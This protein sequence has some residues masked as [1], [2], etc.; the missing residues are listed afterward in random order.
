VLGSESRVSEA[1]R[2]PSWVILT[3]EY[4]PA[5][6]GVAGYVGGLARGLARRGASVDVWS[7]A[8]AGWDTLDGVR[9]HELPHGFDASARRTIERSLLE[10]EDPILLVQYVPLALGRARFARWLTGC[11]AELWVMFHE[12]G[13]PIVLRQSLR[14]RVLGIG[15]H[16]LARHLLVHA[17]R[18]LIPIP[19]WETFLGW[20]GRTRQ[21]PIW[22]PIPGDIPSEPP[23]AARADVLRSHGLDPGR[24]V[25]GLFSAFGSQMAALQRSVLAKLL[26]DDASLQILLI[27]R[28]G[29]GFREGLLAD[30]AGD[31]ERV[32]ATGLLEPSGVADAIRAADVLVMPFAEGVSTRRTSVMAAISLESAV[33]TTEGWATESV[34]SRERC[35][36]LC[37]TDADAI[38]RE[39]LRV[40]RDDGERRRLGERARKVYESRFTMDHV[41]DRVQGLAT[42]RA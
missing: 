41:L 20:M 6:G 18:V 9:V 35:V 15:T 37:P 13:Y 3:P 7:P 30:R 33:V 8:P 16:L 36:V 4:P 21:A 38:S 42:S 12:L 17:D 24:R 5:A 39:V 40:L 32:R 10:L 23:K 2:R 26:T 28:D 11:P 31:A 14:H 1:I 27:G 25:V 29:A 19:A 34:W 22:L